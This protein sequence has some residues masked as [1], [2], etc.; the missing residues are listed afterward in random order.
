[1]VGSLYDANWEI[2]LVHNNLD[3]ENCHDN[4]NFKS[5]Y[6]DNLFILIIA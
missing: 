4:D 2:M 5:T 1:M 3:N 6:H